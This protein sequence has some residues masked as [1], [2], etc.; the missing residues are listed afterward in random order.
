MS[1]IQTIRDK[2]AWIIIGA[3]ALALIAFIV[4]DALQ[5]GSRGLFS[6]NSTTLGKVNG[7]S[8]DVR[9]FE[10]RYKMA[11]D[12]YRAQNYPVN[13]QMRSQIRES[14]WNEFVEDALMTDEYSKLGITISD[15][16]VGDILYGANP[17]Q[18]LKQQFTDSTGMFNAQ[19]AYQ[20]IRS[21]KKGT[22][23]YN[24]F[25]GE[26]VPSLE[27]SRQREK[28][29]SLVG[30]SMYVPKW[31]L[32]KSNA[33][34]SQ[35]AAISYVN[36]PYSTIPDS[37]IKISDDDV[38]DY[39]NKHKDTYKQ[40]N[41]RS[42]IYVSFDASP[43]GTDSAKIL[44]EV[45]KQKDAL[46]AANTTPEIQT[47]MA[48]SASETPYFDGY[49]LS[50]RM[51][52]GNADTLRKLAD[53]QIIGPYLDGPNYTMAKM[54]GRR[55]MPDS[56][57]CRHILIKIGDQQGQ[58][59]TDSAAKKLIDS[60]QTAIAGGANFDSMV[61]KYS[62]DAGSKDKGGEY[63][64][65]SLQFS[66]LSKEFAETIFYGTPG[67]KK[68]VKV[69]NQSYSGY[70]YIEVL[71]QKK[72]ETAFKIAYISHA[73]VPSDETI[74]GASG[75][76]SQFA[77][78][79]RDL[80]QFDDNAAKGKYNKLQADVKESDFMIMGLGETREIIRWAF[81]DAKRGSVAEHPYQVGDKFVV[82]AVTG[83]SEKGTMSVEKARPLV[84]YKVRNEKKAEDI[85]KKIGSASTLEA[86]A[87]ATGQQVFNADS[88]TFNSTFIPNVGNEM[89]V[90]G[91]SFNKEYQTKV[92]AP[93][94]GEIGVFVI[95]V[96]NIS[97]VPNPNFDAKAQQ[98]AIQQQMGAMFG[99]RVMEIM[100]KSADIK[101]NRIKFF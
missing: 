42:L 70:H 39:V 87:Q 9:D 43:S 31:L 93:I 53:G 10:A 22:P 38:R 49:V 20:A 51:Q 62:D 100:K 12:N 90:L 32:E 78:A 54:V 63:E 73:I 91:A 44:E 30:K 57:K 3:I 83:A 81:N 8:I 95:K 5:G 72:I 45:A 41:E 37:T 85:V 101:D 1:V 67:E 92:S 75:M 46:A 2:A 58:A 17:P 4:Q 68:V 86:V 96:N 7:T 29:T 35:R 99:Y 84:E 56:V 55:Q 15:K 34:N 94:K 74:N 82:P 77:A 71:S 60:I 69:D 61:V 64:F 97:A 25:W 14:L 79:S 52:M 26:F 89:K 6:G 48:N 88:V 21:L 40:E 36:V 27:K 80:K 65:A 66:N 23:Q 24:S 98:Q 59:R 50:S 11:E 19:A 33:E 18:M 13:D 16:E 76:A 47:V 28:F